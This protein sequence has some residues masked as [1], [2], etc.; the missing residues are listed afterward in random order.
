MRGRREVIMG[1]GAL[2]LAF[3]A[4]A[5]AHADV[6]AA[7]KPV[8]LKIA[9]ASDL[10]FAFQDIA[11]AFENETGH[12]VI[13]SMGSTGQF[14][15]QLIEGAPFDVFAAANVSFVDDTV[16]AGV[17]DGKTQSMYGQGRLVMWSSKAV[18]LSAPADLAALASD[19]RI[20]KVAIANP[21][22]APYGKAAQ[23]AMTTAGVWAAVKPKLVYGENIQQTMKYAQSGNAEV[24]IVALSLA[25]A[26]KD[27]DYK[28]VDPKLHNEINQAIVVCGNGKDAARASA[29]RAFVDYVGSPEGRATMKR[30]GFVLSGES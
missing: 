2:A 10:A 5:F 27:G 23:E 25:L 3:S 6:A 30:F 22:H 8:T 11:A 13:L 12:R 17:C 20:V 7:P 19:E 26:S 1:A 29:A 4:F 24:A 18:G 21:E 28:L 9:A 15:K 14:A 16:K